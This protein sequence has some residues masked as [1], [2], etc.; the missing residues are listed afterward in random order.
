MLLLEIKKC[1]PEAI[2]FINPQRPPYYNSAKELF[3]KGK[4][5]VAQAGDFVLERAR[6]HPTTEGAGEKQEAPPRT[7]QNVL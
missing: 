5:S 2:Y 1:S 6:R 3:Q 4:N 7:R